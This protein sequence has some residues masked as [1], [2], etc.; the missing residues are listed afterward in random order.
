MA[1]TTDAGF[2]QELMAFIAGV[3]FQSCGA[4]GC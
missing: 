4:G 3:Y 1:E 2:S